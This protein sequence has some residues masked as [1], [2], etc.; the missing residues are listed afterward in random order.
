[1]TLYVGRGRRVEAFC[2]ESPYETVL[3]L[4]SQ[5]NILQNVPKLEVFDYDLDHESTP[6]VRDPSSIAKS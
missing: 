2:A 4:W 5:R 1:M 3:H 6:N